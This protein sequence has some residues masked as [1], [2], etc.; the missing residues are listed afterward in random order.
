MRLIYDTLSLVELSISVSSWVSTQ[1]TH[2]IKSLVLKI[3]EII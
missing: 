2:Q 1:L 3:N